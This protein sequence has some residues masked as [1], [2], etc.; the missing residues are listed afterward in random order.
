[1]L[2]VG[3]ATVADLDRVPVKDLVEHMIFRELFIED[4][5]ERSPNICSHVLA[6]K[7]VVP[8]DVSVAVPSGGVRSQATVTTEDSRSAQTNAGL[9]GT[10]FKTRFANHKSQ[11]FDDPNKRLSTELSIFRPWGTCLSSGSYNCYHWRDQVG[12]CCGWI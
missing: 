11:S 7:W 12:L 9:P 5:K 1:M 10:S 8:D 3:H 6:K 2:E 4:L